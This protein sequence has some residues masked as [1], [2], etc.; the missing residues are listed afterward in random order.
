[1]MQR[2]SH[3]SRKLAVIEAQELAVIEGQELAVIEGQE[4]ARHLAYREA[5]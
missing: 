4:L 3:P 5:A 1:M 2:C